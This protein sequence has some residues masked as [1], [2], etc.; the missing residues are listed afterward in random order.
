M[1]KRYKTYFFFEAGGLSEIY[2]VDMWVGL[3]EGG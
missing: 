2:W 3:Q 1:I